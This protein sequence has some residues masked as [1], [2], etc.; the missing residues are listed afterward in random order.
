MSNG[1]VRVCMCVCVIDI[2]FQGIMVIY[3]NE[4]QRIGWIPSDCDTL[5]KF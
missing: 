3:D 5:P 4:K 1:Y 2:S